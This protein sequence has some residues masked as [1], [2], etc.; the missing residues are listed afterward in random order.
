MANTILLLQPYVDV[1]SG[2]VSVFVGPDVNNAGTTAALLVSNTTAENQ[3]L[4]NAAL[5]AAGYSAGDITLGGDSWEFTAAGGW[6]FTFQ[7]SLAGYKVPPILAASGSSATSSVSPSLS[8]LPANVQS[9]IAASSGSAAS[10]TFT[11]SPTPVGGTYSVNGSAGAGWNNS[12]NPSGWTVASSPAS[13]SITVTAATVG[14]GMTEPTVDA[15]A[16]LSVSGADANQS[17]ALGPSTY[18]ADQG[19]WFVGSAVLSY[20]QTSYY[21]DSGVQA[22]GQSSP[23]YGNGDGTGNNLLMMTDGMGGQTSWDGSIEPGSF[24]DGVTPVYGIT[25]SDGGTWQDGTN[26]TGGQP[27]VDALLVTASAG[28]FTITTEYGTTAAIPFGPWT[29]GNGSDLA[30]AVKAAIIATAGSGQLAGLTVACASFS[31]SSWELSIALPL[32]EGTQSWSAD[33]SGLSNETVLVE[34]VQTAGGGG[35]VSVFSSPIFGE[36]EVMA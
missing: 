9:Y 10:V 29:V 22:S 2:T 32:S 3:S 14:S 4:L 36:M 30:A 20:S 16:L 15:S 23:N 33:G 6:T 19:E 28:S 7:G 1:S 18:P 13:G 26:A 34:S 8:Y 17:F 24:Q 31:P 21:W 27:Q 25:A 12:V 11:F 35:G 5:E